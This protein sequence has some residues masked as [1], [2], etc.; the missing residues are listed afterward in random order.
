MIQF[1]ATSSSLQSSDVIVGLP[2]SPGQARGTVIVLN[3]PSEF[4]PIATDMILVT[5]STNPAWLP[6]L[7]HVSGLVVEV[8]GLLSHGSV[9]AREYGLPGVA[10]IPQATKR[11]RTGDVI[12]VDGSTGVVQLLERSKE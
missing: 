2:I 3:D 5:L 1:G 11:F 8:G 6:L 7:N 12:L 10:N 9:I 4:K